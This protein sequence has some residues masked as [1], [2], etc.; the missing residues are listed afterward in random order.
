MA[1]IL[2]KNVEKLT[3][4]S[5]ITAIASG[6]AYGVCVLLKLDNQILMPSMI[7]VL[8]G[9]MAGICNWFK[10]RSVKNAT[11]TVQP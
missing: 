2:G 7:V 1:N 10:H 8:T 11:P 4:A 6:I 3:Q 9:A 5:I